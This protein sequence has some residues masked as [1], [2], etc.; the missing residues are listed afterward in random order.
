[1]IRINLL[2]TDAPRAA[3]SKPS[4]LQLEQK[5]TLLCSL[6]LVV[7]VLG[8]GWWWWS[9][10]QESA[11]LTT[12][13][14]NAERE[15]ARLLTII[16]QVDQFERQRSQLQ[17]RVSLIEELRKGQAA[18][19]HLLDE[20]SRALPE[21]LWLTELKQDASGELTLDG[22]CTTLTALSDFV[23]N[24]EGS[25]YFQRP[26]DIVNS[27]VTPGTGGGPDLITFTMK[28]RFAVPAAAPPAAAPQTARVQ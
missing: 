26:V 9:L 11:R 10:S 20:V 8:I 5:V 23:G 27:Q 6:L 12:E 17:Q 1:M 3:R 16:Q 14:A 24:L 18:P 7:T 2:A 13:V 15:T 21:M 19:V 25:S 28:A 22:R 4:G